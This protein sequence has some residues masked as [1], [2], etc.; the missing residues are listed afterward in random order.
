M[1]VRGRVLGPYEPEKLQAMV[2]RGQ[3]SRMHDL[4]TDGISWVRASNFPELFVTNVELPAI[5]SEAAANAVNQK[6]A[7]AVAAEVRTSA[8]SIAAAS[9]SSSADAKWYYSRGG[10]QLGPVDQSTLRMMAVSGQL[11]P[12]DLVWSEGMG[13]WQ[14]AT[15][16]PSLAWPQSQHVHGDSRHRSTAASDSS[17]DLPESLTR[18]AVGSRGWVIFVSVTLFV[19]AGLLA[20]SGLGLMV[21]GA[22][23]GLAS[24]VTAGVFSFL[25]AV[26]LAIG[27]YMLIN[28]GSRLSGLRFSRSPA[29]LERA[30]E[31][32]R[33][34]WLYVGIC[35]IVWLVFLV[36]AVVIAAT[37]QPGTF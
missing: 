36:I 32:L 18:A 27:A 11:S 28:Y 1:R 20:L 37:A 4:S 26:V 17:I 5:Q 16:V 35:L 10:A 22:R 7:E 3:L 24:S 2:R 6:G 13:N 29:L 9:P 12:E 15:S 34:F 30:L 8:D 21:N 31:T 33:V 23:V 25:T 19:F 14:P